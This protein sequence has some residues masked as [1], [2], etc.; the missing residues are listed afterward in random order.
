VRRL[1]EH[2]SNGDLPSGIHQ[3]TLAEVVRHFGTSTLQRRI[4]ARRLERIYNL[5]H[6]TG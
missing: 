3:A 1:P 5:A 4:V 2:D 6:G